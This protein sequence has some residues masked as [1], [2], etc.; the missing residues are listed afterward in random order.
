MTRVD[1]PFAKP[2][3]D[4]LVLGPVYHGILSG[5]ALLV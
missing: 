4:M 2:L 3:H 1:L 5:H